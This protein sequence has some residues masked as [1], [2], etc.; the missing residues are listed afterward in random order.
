MKSN[1]QAV[2]LKKEVIIRL[3]NAFY[4]KIF[5][6]SVRS[7][8]Y[9]MRP[10]GFNVEYRCCIYKERAII[11]DRIV[12][13]LGFSI[14]ELDERTSLAEYATRALE[15]K[16][17]EKNCLTVLDTACK[18][19]T[20]NRVFVTDLCQGC[21]ARPCQSVCKFGA[22]SMRD[23]KSFIDK[24]ECKNCKMC[25]SACPYNAITKIEV[26]CEQ[27]CPVNA[28]SKDENGLAKINFDK[29]IMCGKCIEAC[30]FGAVYEKSQIID[31]LKNIKDGKKVIALLAPS[32]AGQ[33]PGTLKQLQSAIL[34]LGFSDVYEVALGADIT[35]KNEAKEFK[36]KVCSDQ[37]FMTT[38]CCA[39]YHQL[40]EKHLKELLPFVS[41]TR[42]PLYY[43]A[44]LV[45]KMNKDA[46]VVFISPCIAKKAEV[47]DNKD[48][49]Y[50]I[51]FKEL[52]AWFVAKRIEIAECE[53]SSFKDVSTIY[54]KQFGISNGVLNAVENFLMNDEK[55]NLK[56]V[57]IDGLDKI[58]IA[59]LRKI[60]KDKSCLSG[61]LIE[62]M[63]CKGG[64]VGGNGTIN[65]SRQATQQILTIDK[66]KK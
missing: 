22:M 57:C 11:K 47:E 43:T 31:V 21:V 28:I 25:I 33:L 32:I 45:R 15:R 62:V 26:P 60:A 4:E 35:A 51:N 29:C 6:E 2:R 40:L 44:E 39:C 18:G 19:C 59:Q 46:I 12:A 10:K 7:I 61:N 13:D 41:S 5:P 37:P 42:T 1:D 54:G 8:P 9:D 24:E 49:D 20:P 53:E 56:K 65:D 34:K 48:I 64:C 16:E 3:I 14:D 52:G 30:P 17:P 58:S 23:G 50:V 27:A 66:E 38:S 63:S 36:E 55:T